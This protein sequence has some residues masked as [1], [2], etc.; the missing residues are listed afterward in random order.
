[1]VQLGAKDGLFNMDEA[2]R[3]T[4][5]AAEFYKKLGVGSRFEFN[6]HQGGHEFEIESIFKFFGRYL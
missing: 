6:V 3:E 5:R 4:E 1:M 2:K